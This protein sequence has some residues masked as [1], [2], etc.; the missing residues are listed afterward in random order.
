MTVTPNRMF[1]PIS[2]T[3]G[4][5]SVN[6]CCQSLTASG[7]GTWGNSCTWMYE[8]SGTL[9]Y[10][11]FALQV[12]TVEQR[13][14]RM[15]G[16]GLTCTCRIGPVDYCITRS[17]REKSCAQGYKFRADITSAQLYISRTQPRYT[18]TPTRCQYRLALVVEGRIGLVFATQLKEAIAYTKLG[19]TD[20]CGAASPDGCKPTDSGS[21]PI[22]SPPTFNPALVEPTANT[23]RRVYRA[24]VDDLTFPITM[25]AGNT[26]SDSCGP[27][28]AENFSNAAVSLSTAPDFSCEGY[29]SVIACNNC[30][31]TGSPGY[32]PSCPRAEDDC[33]STCDPDGNQLWLSYTG[34]TN[35]EELRSDSG[36]VTVGSL[37]SFDLPDS[38]EVNLT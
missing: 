19:G 15:L 16:M 18:C 28:C 21:Y 38:F 24:S 25:S 7:C 11:K 23:W 5:S 35:T 17:R 27:K 29:P 26:I 13:W 2:V 32:D 12:Y 10:Q 37:P 4:F 30:W 9:K 34:Y 22:P 36:V 33:Q 6:N 31:A 3:A 20:F 14:K 1:S 8:A